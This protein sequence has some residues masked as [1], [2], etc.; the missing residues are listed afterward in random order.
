MNAFGWDC[1]GVSWVIACIT[2]ETWLCQPGMLKKNQSVP[3]GD[4]HF[5]GMLTQRHCVSQ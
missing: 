1:P 3:E 5:C 2:E 4:T